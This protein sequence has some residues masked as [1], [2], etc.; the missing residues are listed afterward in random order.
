MINLCTMMN[1]ESKKVIFL[2]VI[3]IVFSGILLLFTFAL[4]QQTTPITLL[5]RLTS[6]LYIPTHNICYLGRLGGLHA[7]SY[8]YFLIWLSIVIIRFVR[9]KFH[10]QS[11]PFYRFVVVTTFLVYFLLMAFQTVN[12]LKN[13]IQEW[14]VFHERSKEERKLI[15]FGDIY[16]F[17]KYCQKLLPGYHRSELITDLDTSR[18]PGMYMHRALA[19]HLYPIDIRSVHADEP[20]DSVVI[21]HKKG[22]RDFVPDGFAIKGI[23]NEYNILAVKKDMAQ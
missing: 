10:L 18:D 3:V 12:Q 19:Y 15:I 22:A 16:T 21:Y 4:S 6:I 23:F 13:F 17:A 7:Y 1:Q 2:S 8:F 14:D 11:I 20:M 5:S 9:I